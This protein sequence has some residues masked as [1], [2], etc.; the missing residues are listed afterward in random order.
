MKPQNTEYEP[1]TWWTGLCWNS[2]AKKATSTGKNFLGEKRE[3]SRV[4]NHSENAW[5]SSC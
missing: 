1:L 4:E 2:S 5:F 3:R